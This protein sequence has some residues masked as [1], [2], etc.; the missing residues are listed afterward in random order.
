MQMK[1]PF[2]WLFENVDEK[3]EDSVINPTEI[4]TPFNFS[5][6]KSNP[7]ITKIPLDANEAIIETETTVDESTSE[8][9]TIVNYIQKTFSEAN[10]PGPDYFEYA[11][12][13]ESMKNIIIDES[14]RYNAAYAAL[15]H[16][17]LTFE[18]I[19]ESAN[20]YNKML[21]DILKK[22]I[23]ASNTQKTIQIG[24]AQ[25][26]LE[27][28]RKRNNEIEKELKENQA[29]IFSLESKVT[30]A[31]VSLTKKVNSFKSVCSKIS[32]QIETHITNIKMY[33]KQ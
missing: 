31:E 24:N 21:S 7:V 23:E 25:K 3:K 1:K 18:K 9:P 4:S 28:L 5:D 27:I 26:E 32:Q 2:G 20:T 33:I 30:D 16:S 19:V 13:L 17:G 14:Q 12:S 6:I 29:A 8:D 10:L 22:F 15:V 11:Q